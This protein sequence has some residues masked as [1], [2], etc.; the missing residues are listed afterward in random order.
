[1]EKLLTIELTV[2]EFNFLHAIL[3]DLPTKSNAWVLLSNLEKQAKAQAEAQNIPVA[4]ASADAT[5]AE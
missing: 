3:G 2:S 4:G 5:Q 1:M